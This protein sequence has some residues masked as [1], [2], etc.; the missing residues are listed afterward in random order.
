MDLDKQILGDLIEKQ[1]SSIDT[2][3]DDAFLE[4]FG[5]SLL[6]VQDKENLEHIIVQGDPIESFRYRGETFLYLNREMKI[7]FGKRKDNHD[8]TFSTIFRKV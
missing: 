6:D 2:I 4:H 1:L 8:I 7:K 3:I 5:F